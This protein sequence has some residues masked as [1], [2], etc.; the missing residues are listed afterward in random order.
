MSKA[1]KKAVVAD[2][3]VS[4]GTCVKECPMGALSIP[5]GIIAIVDLNKC[6]GCGKCAKVCPA[7]AIEIAEREASNA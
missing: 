4:C 2:H 5:Q 1:K 7:N 6:V 3:C